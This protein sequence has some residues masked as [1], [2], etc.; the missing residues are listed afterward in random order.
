MTTVASCPPLLRTA[1]A[2][3]D[4]RDSH[5]ARKGQTG[6]GTREGGR[7]GERAGGREGG[8]EGGEAEG[9]RKS[10]REREGA[11]VSSDCEDCPCRGD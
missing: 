3:T 11:P 7:V 10:E 1:K 5:R 4:L 6:P 9:E 2:Y 8:R